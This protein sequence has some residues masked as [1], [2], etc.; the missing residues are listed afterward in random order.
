MGVEVIERQAD[1]R[2]EVDFKKTIEVKSCR[3]LAK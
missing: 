2:A 3:I 1:D